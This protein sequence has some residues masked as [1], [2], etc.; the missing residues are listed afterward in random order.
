M[1][2]IYTTTVTQSIN[3]LVMYVVNP[4]FFLRDVYITVQYDNQLLIAGREIKLNAS[5]T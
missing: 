4:Y 2:M 1:K 3:T 5:F